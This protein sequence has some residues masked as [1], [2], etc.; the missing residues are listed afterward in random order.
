LEYAVLGEGRVESEV[1]LVGGEGIVS[2]VELTMPM[3]MRPEEIASSK[4]VV[5]EEAPD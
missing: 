2:E 1:E 5:E 4:L 3:L